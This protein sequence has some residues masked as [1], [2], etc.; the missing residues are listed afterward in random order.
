MKNRHIIYIVVAVLLLASCSTTE[1]VPDGDQL[2]I[3]LTKIDYRNYEKND[4]FILAQEEVEAAL[5]TKPNGALFGS[6]YYRTPFPYGL[7]VWNAFQDSES[8][9]GKWMTKAFGKAPVLMSQVNPALRASVAH[10]LLRNHGYFHNQVTYEAV[11]QR[12]PKKGKIGYT[13]DLGHL[14]TLDTVAYVGFPAEA[15]S[16]IRATAADALIRK[17]SPF[18][19]AGLDGERKRLANLFRNNGYYYY[20]PGYASFLAD[21][22]A[23]PGKAQLRLQLA[24]EIPVQATHKW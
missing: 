7:W 5:A 16:L 15:D 18:T 13:V 14:F 4:N 10:S 11:P 20:Q 2:F 23:V 22:L 19:V 17:G 6:S 21:T 1:H 8:K 3:G 9:F 24:D 12:N